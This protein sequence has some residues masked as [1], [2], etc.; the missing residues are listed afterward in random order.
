MH[1]IKLTLGYSSSSSVN[2]V[3]RFHPRVFGEQQGERSVHLY[4][5]HLSLHIGNRCACGYG[6]LT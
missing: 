2:A 1:A 5:A 3:N 4:L 6:G